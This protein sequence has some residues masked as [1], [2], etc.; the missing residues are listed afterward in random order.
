MSSR[1]LLR[2]RRPQEAY[3]GVYKKTFIHVLFFNMYK[4]QR[5]VGYIIPILKVRKL[6]V[7]GVS[8]WP[9]VM[10]CIS[11]KAASAPLISNP[12]PLSSLP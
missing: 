1:H 12:S 5:L 7:I 2:W 11:N 4:N 10:R 3:S 6:R 9:K 8:N